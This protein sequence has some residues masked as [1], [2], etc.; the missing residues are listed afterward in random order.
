MARRHVPDLR[1]CFRGGICCNSV[2]EATQVNPACPPHP[3]THAMAANA[4]TMTRAQRPPLIGG[5][6]V[7][8]CIN[9]GAIAVAII[10]PRS[11][12][13]RPARRG[14][15]RES[16]GR[17]LAAAAA[18]YGAILLLPLLLLHSN[19]ESNV[20]NWDLTHSRS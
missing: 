17:V 6:A 18:S 8:F 12:A 5:P 19:I 13:A 14:I 9:V 20:S 15:R 2:G 3:C 16:D 1:P 4:T 11:G 10:C 7:R